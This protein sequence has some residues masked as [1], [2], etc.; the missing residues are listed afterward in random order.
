MNCRGRRADV[1]RERRKCPCGEVRHCNTC[2]K[3]IPL[4]TA[5]EN[6]FFLGS[7]ALADFDFDLFFLAQDIGH[8]LD[9][10][11]ADGVAVF[12]KLDLVALHQ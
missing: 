4:F 7:D 11:L 6:F 9:H 10:V 3:D 12:D 8:G 2:G 1:L 5:F